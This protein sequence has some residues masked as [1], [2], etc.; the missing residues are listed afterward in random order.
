MIMID[1][2][3]DR[4]NRKSLPWL[5]E[6]M[7]RIGNN[8]HTSDGIAEDIIRSFIQLAS[9]EMHYKTL[10]EKSVSELENGIVN[11]DSMETV[12]KQEE[13]IKML[14]E[15]LALAAQLRRD[16]MLL[17]Y[18][19]YGSKGDKRRWCNVKHLS[20]AMMTAFEAYQASD[21]N[22]RLFNSYLAKNRMLIKELSI[23]LGVEITECAACFADALKGV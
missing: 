3:E 16:D 20:I 11:V 4:S 12:V 1:K 10:I 17:L 21:D 7:D 19:M 23:F 8:P 2:K 9:M 14:R 18:E 5:G 13:I 22:T 6:N 15:D